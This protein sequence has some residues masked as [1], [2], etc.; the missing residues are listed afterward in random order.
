MSSGIVSRF[1]RPVN[2]ESL[3][4]LIRETYKVSVRRANIPQELKEALRTNER[5]PLFLRNIQNEVKRL[6]NKYQTADT[7]TNLV[8]ELTSLFLNGIVKKVNEQML[9]D[10]EKTRMITADNKSKILDRAATTGII[11]E[12]VLSVLEEKN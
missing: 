11:D 7:V 4:K 5:V 10:A 12:E 3:T 8:K 1:S 6:P 9:S 2:D